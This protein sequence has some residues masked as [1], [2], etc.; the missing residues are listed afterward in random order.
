MKADRAKPGSKGRSEQS[1]ALSLSVDFCPDVN[2]RAREKNHCALTFLL[3][4]T[5]DRQIYS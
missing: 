1:P 4:E 2:N 5:K 3:Q